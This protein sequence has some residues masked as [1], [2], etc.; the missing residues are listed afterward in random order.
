MTHRCYVA[1]VIPGLGDPSYPTTPLALF[2]GDD[3]V[4]GA[5]AYLNTPGLVSVNPMSIKIDPITAALDV[6]AASVEILTPPQGLESATGMRFWLDSVLTYRPK[7]AQG[8]LASE[9]DA[10]GSTATVT[11]FSRDGARF[12]EGDVIYIEREAIVLG[13]LTGTSAGNK[14][15]TFNI[16]QRGAFGTTRRYHVATPGTGAPPSPVS[17][18]DNRVYTRPYPVGLECYIVEYDNNTDS[19]EV[20]W[21]GAITQEPKHASG[22]ASMTLEIPDVWALCANRKLNTQ[23]MGAAGEGSK[24]D[25]FRQYDAYYFDLLADPFTQQ[26]GS[27][28]VGESSPRPAVV[29]IDKALVPVQ[30]VDDANGVFSYKTFGITDSRPILDSKAG[31]TQSEFDIAEQG[32]T[33]SPEFIPEVLPIGYA[34]TDSEGN[35]IGAVYAVGAEPRTAY[36]YITAWLHMLL[37]TGTGLNS[38]NYD[39]WA[40]TLGLGLPE[41]VVDVA[42]LADLR[43]ATL[44]SGAVHALFFGEGGKDFSSSEF[45]EKLLPVFGAFPC[46]TSDYKIT[47]RRLE[48][49]TDAD[50][51]I[52]ASQITVFSEDQVYGW[53]GIANSVKVTYKQPWM[54]QTGTVTSIDRP[55]Y[56][57][58]WDPAPDDP[59]M[60]RDV[61]GLRPNVQLDISE[62]QIASKALLDWVSKPIPKYVFEVN[63]PPAHM[64]PGMTIKL[65]IEEG[66]YYHGVFYDADG[67]RITSGE[68]YGIATQVEC[69]FGEGR[70]TVEMWA[71]NDILVANPKRIAP[72]FV[73]NS[74]GAGY[75]RVDRTSLS[76]ADLSDFLDAAVTLRHYKA[77]TGEV[78]WN[79]GASFMTVVSTT[80]NASTID[81][82]WDTAPSVSP[83]AGDFLRVAGRGAQTSTVTGKYAFMASD[84]EVFLDGSDGDIYV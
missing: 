21:R 63:Q 59:K 12:S 48:V 39:R 34:V 5:N 52:N 33:T 83:V 20:R 73:V 79:G 9:L 50:I 22:T 30:V 62:R 31:D 24:I 46:V 44:D 32:N 78:T 38:T 25:Y 60:V 76:G 42:G 67:E 10:G 13:S 29:Q 6:G 75:V 55:R 84:L 36:H 71:I 66:D 72:T 81:L 37:S 7:E 47:A 65:V 74:V 16:S 54:D 11:L 28:L 69:A 1:L 27:I 43:S 8:L 23:P 58:W 17:G 61:T 2:L 77:A 41:A 56:T 40:Y 49:V 35:Y 18:F 14:T 51:T 19:V 57:T 4:T 15:Q 64:Y 53:E 45:T 82:Y 26:Y 80:V 3:T 70:Y 68:V